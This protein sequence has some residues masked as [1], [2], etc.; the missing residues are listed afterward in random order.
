MVD[1]KGLVTKARPDLEDSKAVYARD[2]DEIG[3]YRCDD[4]SRITL[5]DTVVN[6]LPSVL[7][8]TSG[9]PEIFT[10]PI[11][12]RMSAFNER[13]IVFPLSNPTSKSEGNPQ[14][15]LHWS[16]GRAIIATGSPFPPATIDG[17]THRIGQGNNAFIFPGVG[18]GAWVAGIRRI[19]D[20]MF[21]E[22]ARALAGMVR[23]EDLAS[24]SVFPELDRIRACSH[25][26][27][28]AVIRAA[29]ADGL[30]NEEQLE[31]V[32]NRVQRAMWFPEY[33]AV[34]YERH[35]GWWSDGSSR[36]G[37]R[38]TRTRS[39]TSRVRFS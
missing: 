29:V 32:E 18:L 8:G 20:R 4:H 28:C 33:R 22:A 37:R 34:R 36:A 26:V 19:N 6:T 35:A 11:I 25:A 3:G 12:E 38:I 9:K 13:P 17:R 30:A 5:M 7:I 27:A 10:Q 23:S 2:I 31:D 24:S 15:I 1:S 14:Q 16:R 21:L 39:R